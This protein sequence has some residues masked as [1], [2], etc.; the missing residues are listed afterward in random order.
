MKN[1]KI[2]SILFF[3]L[4]LSFVNFA[5][6]VEFDK[7]NF[8]E[9]KDGLKAAKEN[10]AVGNEIFEKG[11]VFY[12]DAIVHYEKA[13]NFNPNNADLNYKLG[14]CYLASMYKLKAQPFL[15]KALQLNPN[16]DPTIQ[17]YLGKSYHL[18]L[19]WDQ[20]IAAYSKFQKTAMS[21]QDPKI[22][23]E[24]TMRIKQCY[25]G[26]D[27]VKTPIRV[28]IDN[29]G[30]NINSI[31]N[32]YGA[33]ISA[34]ESVL[35]Y[36]SRRPGSTGGKIDPYLNEQ[37]EDIYISERQADGTWSK[38]TNLPKPVNSDNHDA[39]SGV[40]A[41]GQKFIIYLGKNNGG[42]LFE[43]VLEGKEWSKPEPFNKNINTKYHEPTGCY[44]PDGNAIYFVSDRPDG[45][46]DHDIYVSYKDDKGKWGE[47]I[48]LG[49]TINTKYSEEGI[50]MHPDGKTIYFSSQGHNSMGGFDIFKSIFNQETKT[51]SKP[52]NIGYPVNTPDDDVFFVISANGRHGYYTSFDSKSLGLR[53][54][55]IITFLGPEKQM[56][57]N[58]EDN[59]IASAAKPV[60]ETV[61]AAEVE[62][63]EAQLT[64]LRGVITDAISKEFLSAEIEIVDNSA[65]K[66]IATFKSNSSTGKYLV[67]LPA[68]KNYGIAVKKD[69]YLFHSENFDIP[70]TAAFQEVEKD[71][72]LK[73]L[74]VGGTIVLKNI[75]FDFDKATLR[76]ESTA[77]LNRLIKLMTD[78]PTLKI[79]LGGHTD[80]KGADEYNQKLSENRAK[81]VVDYLVKAGITADRLKSAGYGETK[82]ISTN[83]TDAGRQLNRRTEFKVLS[84]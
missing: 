4:T 72:E 49:A 26:R 43:S 59:L 24:T 14:Q 74:A 45:L 54:L 77:E 83:E 62:V 39:N 57:L 25:N 65:N 3:M 16:I 53:D 63:R 13:Q 47:A 42:D 1:L 76:P 66:V 84:L 29:L 6:N 41:D 81:A 36:T 7:D 8:K 50:Y 11:P 22:G 51:W 55:Y 37:F 46:G 33:V 28:F 79:E 2:V 82:P 68:G 44:S 58:N 80:S 32:D 70:K 56:I 9:N 15:E 30:P 75:F 60:E 67:S 23:E 34:D 38:G 21:N 73:K 18:N 12:K 19:S 35:F 40:S 5:Q 10:L 61:I 52:E 78:V 48:N 20:A 71:V 64:L 31:Y 69:G 17:Y 27:L